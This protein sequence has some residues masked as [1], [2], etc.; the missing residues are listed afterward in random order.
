MKERERRNLDKGPIIE[1]MRKRVREYKIQKEKK[2][3]RGEYARQRKNQ[4]VEADEETINNRRKSLTTNMK[5]A[6]AKK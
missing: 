6:M 1:K 4:A 2:I 3:Q 5:E